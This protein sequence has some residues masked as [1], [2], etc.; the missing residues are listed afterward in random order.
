MV[1]PYVDVQSG[2]AL[3]HIEGVAG[4]DNA[5]K[6]H[7]VFMD[8]VECH[9]PVIL[10]AE[11]MTE[12]DSSFIQ[13]VRSLCYTLHHGGNVTLQFWQDRMPEALRN[14]M[15]MTGFQFHSVC[16][17]LDNADCL[18]CKKTQNLDQKQ[19]RN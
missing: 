5:A 14:I 10:D 9:L 6:I 18:C 11:R 16:T 8:A 3:V 12:C 1:E 7:Q 19:G 4:I 17:R 2:N 15:E 13:L